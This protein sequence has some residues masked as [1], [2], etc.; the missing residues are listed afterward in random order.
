MTKISTAY[1]IYW[2]W[3][4]HLQAIRKANDGITLIFDYQ[5]FALKECDLNVEDNESLLQFLKDRDV[6]WNI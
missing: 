1:G 2:V 4:D 3:L 5:E 6:E